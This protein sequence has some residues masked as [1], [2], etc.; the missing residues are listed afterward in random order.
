MADGHEIGVHSYAKTIHDTYNTLTATQAETD[1]RLAAEWTANNGFPGTSY[2]YPQGW[3]FASGDPA[4]KLFTNGRTVLNALAK[5]NPVPA[6]DPY[7]VRSVSSVGGLGSANTAASLTNTGGVLEKAVA[8]NTAVILTFHVITTTAPTGPTDCLQ[9][10]L[11]AIC[12]KIRALGMAVVPFGR[13]TNP[14]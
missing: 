8:A 11:D 12:A 7:R 1:F 13:L 2:A 3:F 14:A 5:T 9:S 10:D 6:I 4:R